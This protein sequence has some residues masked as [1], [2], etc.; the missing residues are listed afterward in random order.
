LRRTRLDHRSARLRPGVFNHLD[1]RD[2]SVAALREGFD[3]PRTLGRIPQRLTQ[4][5]HRGVQPMIEVDERVGRPELLPKR[6]AADQ[7]PA[8]TQEQQ[9]DVEGTASQFD[10][11]TLLAQLA[12]PAVDLE[13]AESIETFGRGIRLH[14]ERVWRNSILVSMRPNRKAQPHNV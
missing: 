8:P 9:K 3:E 1:R 11:P 10:D 13:K 14:A 5:V 6:V 2:E 12:E 4:A 7:V